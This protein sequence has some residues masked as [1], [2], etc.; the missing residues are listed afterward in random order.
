MG[1]STHRGETLVGLMVGMAVGMI[2]VAAVVAMLVST[3]GLNAQALSNSYLNQELKTIM[4]IMVRDIRRAQY[5]ATALDCM[6]AASCANAFTD[7]PEDWTVAATQIL[8]S[9]DQDSNGTQDSGECSGFRRTVASSTGNVEKRYSCRPSWQSL[10]DA[11]SVAIDDLR[12]SAATRCVPAGD[13]FLAVREL[14]I[15]LE[16]SHA[17][18]TRRMCQKVRIKNDLPTP[19]CS[20]TSIATSAPFDL[21][22]P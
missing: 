14:K 10:S 11:A 16:G 13:G 21:C 22:P 4:D 5:S 9:Y 18:T 7:G 8:Y 3:L 2:V 15:Y 1:S 12:F 19:T 20:A 17:G 6:G